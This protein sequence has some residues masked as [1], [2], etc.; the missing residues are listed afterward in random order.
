MKNTAARILC[1]LCVTLTC[2]VAVPGC[3]TSQT[4][5]ETSQAQSEN[6]QYMSRVNQISQDIEESLADFEAAIAAGDVAA[7]RTAMNAASRSVDELASIDAPDALADIKEGY[8]EGSSE[9]REA[10]ADYVQLYT[11]VEASEGGIDE[12]SYQERLTDIQDRYSEALEKIS[13]ADELAASL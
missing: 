1:A 9:L 2:V 12:A 3:T 10:L 4:T 5:S 6:R 8:V 13:D 7:M 11:E